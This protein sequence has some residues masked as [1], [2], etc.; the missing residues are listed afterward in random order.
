MAG[1][2]TSMS[3]EP[4]A[5]MRSAPGTCVVGLVKMAASGAVSLFITGGAASA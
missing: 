2:A 3:G 4:A 5:G 1:S